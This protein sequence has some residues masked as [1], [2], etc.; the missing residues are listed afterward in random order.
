MRSKLA[1]YLF[2]HFIAHRATSSSLFSQSVRSFV[3]FATQSSDPPRQR[4]TAIT[5]AVT[6]ACHISLGSRTAASKHPPH[7][8]E[9]HLPLPWP[10]RR[11][12]LDSCRARALWQQAHQHNAVGVLA[13]H[14]V[15]DR[16][17]AHEGD[18]GVV[19]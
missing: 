18:A 1:V 9:H 10:W 16:D 8:A 17:A 4:T 11:S 15:D 14:A 3:S 6:G 12:W 7:P 2:R 5:G 13:A 19:A